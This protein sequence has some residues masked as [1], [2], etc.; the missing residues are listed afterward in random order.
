MASTLLVEYLLAQLAGVPSMIPMMLGAILA[1]MASFG[2]SDPTRGGQAITMLHIPLFMAGGMAI[3]LSVDRNRLA[4]LVVFV[5]VMVAAVVIRRFGPRYFVAGMVAFIGYFF[6][7]F[8]QLRVEQM[9]LVLAAIAVATAWAM[10]LALV[11]LPVRN[12]RV[13]RRLV[14][15]FEARVQAAAAAAAELVAASCPPDGPAA[16]HRSE[17]LLAT[18]SSRLVR[19]NEA[20][21]IIDGQLGSPG[22]VAGDAAAEAVRRALF[23]GEL[24]ASGVADGARLLAACGHRLPVPVRGPATS[25]LAALRTGRWDAVEDAARLLEDVSGS[26]VGALPLAAGTQPGG[27]PLDTAHVVRRMAASAQVL[28]AARRDWT[29]A[30]AAADQSGPGAGFVPAVQLFGGAMPG[31]AKTVQEM[32]DGSG[33]R[34]WT[35]LSLSTRQ[36]VQ[37]GIATA[38]AIAVGDAV[39]GQRYYWAVL[40]AFIAFTGTATSAET[41]AKAV[42]R[43]LGTLIGIGLAIPL[44]ALTGHS[45]EVGLPIALLSI[46]G[47]F[48]L[49]RVSY[50]LMTF[51]ITLLLG[52]LYALIGTFTPALM[53][54]RLEETAIGG[55]IGCAVALLVLPTRA[56]TAA[57]L[58]RRL[59]LDQLDTLLQGLGRR[60]RDPD[61]DVDLHADARALD[62]RLHQLLVLTRPLVRPVLFAPDAD[63]QR[64]LRTYTALAHHARRLAHLAEQD[65]DLDGARR[66]V[67]A[68]AVEGIGVLLEALR[69]EDPR[70][71]PVAVTATAD[72]LAGIDVADQ[73]V[74]A[75]VHELGYLHE[76]LASLGGSSGVVLSAAPETGGAPVEPARELAGRVVSGGVP[77]QATITLVDVRG[78]QRGRATT[79][80]DGGYRLTPPEAGIHLLICTPTGPSGSA[81][82][83]VADWVLVP[84]G[85][86]AHDIALDRPDPAR[87]RPPVAGGRVQPP[88]KGG[89]TSTVA[90]CA[91]T[92]ARSRTANSSTR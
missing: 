70:P 33:G 59:I 31:A 91:S 14:R 21:L 83:P 73:R 48:Y 1:L 2:I 41:V 85:A 19:V 13:L 15:A 22:A 49:L 46:F 87:H 40:A 72:L 80:P 25:L 20:A 24:A 88:A 58:A 4:S 34:W 90:P 39:S 6:A 30:P 86:L 51:F 37:V 16:A 75:L 82:E 56:G 42:N 71:D 44:V 60:L 32:L 92:R 28:V 3:A 17:K 81:G 77:A 36:A 35:R 29:A 76:A 27:V 79:A 43:V 67:L 12:D 84:D 65:R 8:L 10:L 54:L 45:I 18:L 57:T 61:A 11:L 9:P 47:A 7:L 52:E 53:V 66:A 50:A 62:A 68:S 69:A 64:R 23:D 5:A 38:L 78:R 89:R 74:R 55:V 63:R 26:L